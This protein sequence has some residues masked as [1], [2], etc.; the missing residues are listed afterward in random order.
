MKWDLDE[1]HCIGQRIA[2]CIRRLHRLALSQDR[3]QKCHGQAILLK[4]G[5]SGSSAL[6]NQGRAALPRRRG[7]GDR[8]NQ[9]AQIG[10]DL[11]PSVKS[12]DGI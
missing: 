3:V 8:I 12:A 5:Q 6:P 4:F 7:G 2:G 1:R 9:T 10:F 11:R